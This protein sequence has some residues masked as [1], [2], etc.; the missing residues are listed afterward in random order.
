MN[1]KPFGIQGRWL[2]DMTVP[3][4]K[5]KISESFLIGHFEKKISTMVVV[6]PGNVWSGGEGIRIDV[7]LGRI[8]ASKSKFSQIDFG[9]DNGCE[10]YF[11]SCVLD[12]CSFAKS[13]G[14][15]GMDQSAKSYFENCVI[16]KRFAS[17]MNVPDTGFRAQ[18]CVFEKIEFAT[19]SFFNKEPADYVNHPWERLNNCRFIECEIPISVLLLTRD[20]LFENCIFVDD[21]DKKNGPYTKPV[22][23]VVYTYN[24]K[25]R[26]TT[27]PANVKLTEKAHTDWKGSPLPTIETLKGM[28]GQ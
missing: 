28:M 22:E 10:L 8:N 19:F 23:A 27:L 21:R 15:W 11:T 25:S 26:I 13:G 24:C 3:A 2:E 9:G 12:D 18:T 5:Q 20:C 1:E 16:S 6:S 7:S 4:L 14:W 17:K